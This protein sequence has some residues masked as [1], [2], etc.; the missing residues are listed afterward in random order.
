LNSKI[1]AHLALLSANL[2][3]ALNY[4]LAKDVM[5]NYIQPSGFILLRVI[6]AIILFTVC[7]IFFVKEKICSK[8]LALFF[9]CGIL[10]VTI[11]QL[12]FFQGLNLTTPINAAIIM[13]TNPI[14]VIVISLIFLK[15]QITIKKTAGVFF[16]ILGATI[17]ISNNGSLDFNNNYIK[18]NLFIFLN[19]TSYALY[20]VL[21][22]PLIKKYNAVTVMMIVFLFGSI[23]VIP[24]GLDELMSVEWMLMP[25]IIVLEVLFVLI[26]TTFLAYLLNSSA[27]KKLNPTT[28]STYIYLQP[29]LASIFAILLHSDQFDTTKIVSIILVFFGI[30][31]V[32]V[33]KQNIL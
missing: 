18:G 31:L 32:S 12:F 11:N 30:Y 20:L 26:F 6:S 21:V 7:Y 22:K 16:G 28:V 17:L 5:P 33:D 10:G 25:K 14:L 9:L 24:F 3:Y 8:D 27:L 13:T 19:A 15:E 4:T 29:I 2:I 1:L 23:F